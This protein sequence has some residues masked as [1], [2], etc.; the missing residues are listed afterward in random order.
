MA[1]STLYGG[2]LGDDGLD[3][4]DSLASYLEQA[5]EA[6]RAEAGLD[7]LP[8]EG[9][10]DRLVFM[11]GI[12]RGVIAYLADH[13]SALRITADHDASHTHDVAAD[14]D[15]AHE[16]GGWAMPDRGAAHEHGGAVAPRHGDA[17][18][19]GGHVEV[20]ADVP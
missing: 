20:E 10:R 2:R 16:H 13:G 1:S 17:H 19:H 14:H 8:E 6:V 15:G 12:A 7:P 4:A 5:F 11:L 9:R 18:R 3:T